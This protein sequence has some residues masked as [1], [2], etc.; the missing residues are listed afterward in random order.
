MTGLYLFAAAAG[1]PLV[2]W[3]LLSG[4]DDGGDGG[5]GDEGLAGLAFRLLPL[6]TLA[7]ILATFGVCGLALGAAGTGDGTTLVASLVV[8]AVV[9]ALNSAA[10]TFLRRTGSTSEVSDRR[11][12]G[13]TGRVVLPVAGERRGRV[14]IDVAGQQVYLSAQTMPDAPAELEVGAPVLVV[15]VEGGIA[16]VTR[17]DPELT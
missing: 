11:L 6:S 3:F 13:A 2:A 16:R 9:G 15:E 7:I 4:G 8:A 12:A 17:L 5:G 1:V 10:L 14:A